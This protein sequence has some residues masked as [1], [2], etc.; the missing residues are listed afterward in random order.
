[1]ISSSKPQVNDT[2][3]YDLDDPWTTQLPARLYS[4][5]KTKVTFLI[6]DEERHR[7]IAARRIQRRLKGYKARKLT[8]AQL[9]AFKIQQRFLKMNINKIKKVERT[10]EE[11]HRILVEAAVVMQRNWRNLKK[12]RAKQQRARER[13]L[14]LAIQTAGAGDAILDADGNL[15]GLTSPLSP[16]AKMQAGGS[17]IMTPKVGFFLEV[18]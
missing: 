15:I 14:E 1:M 2:L 11:E 10:E 12:K 5:R 13:Q 17:A 9:R 16:K 3:F 8:G 4:G 6:T 7:D 18:L